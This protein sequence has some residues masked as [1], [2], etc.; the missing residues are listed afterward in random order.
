MG[1]M[2]V[3]VMNIVGASDKIVELFNTKPSINTEGGEKLENP[4]GRL[5]IKDVKFKYPTK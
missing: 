4:N 3:N 5:E 2:A 1:W